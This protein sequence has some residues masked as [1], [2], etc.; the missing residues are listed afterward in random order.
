M[1]K[2]QYNQYDG[3]ILLGL[4]DTITLEEEDVS[5]QPGSDL[6]IFS[7]LSCQPE[8][9]VNQLTDCIIN[10]VKRHLPGLQEDVEMNFQLFLKAFRI[11]SFVL[12]T[13]GPHLLESHQ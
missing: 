6:N 5:E 7:V 13:E 1:E 11:I 2:L 12:T 3:P 8:A 4:L 9:V 10:V